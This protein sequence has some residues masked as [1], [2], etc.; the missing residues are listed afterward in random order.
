MLIFRQSFSSSVAPWAS[1]TQVSPV[2]LVT[3]RSKAWRTPKA[4]SRG[5]GPSY[6]ERLGFRQAAYIFKVTLPGYYKNVT[7][8]QYSYPFVS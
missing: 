1:E 3:H 2:E 8:P 5:P 4:W 6:E 7:L